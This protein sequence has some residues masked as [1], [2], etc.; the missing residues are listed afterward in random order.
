MKRIRHTLELAGVYL[1]LGISRIVPLRIAVKG[2]FLLGILAFD[3]FRIRRKVTL[4]NLGRALGGEM[5]PEE[6][7]EV[8]R[9]S[10]I[11][12][13]KSVI[14]FAAMGHLKEKD[15]RKLVTFRG[16]ENIETHLSG[17]DGIM[18]VAGH[19]GSW[20]LMGAASAA[21]GYPVDFLVGEQSN[22]MVNNLMNRLRSSA[23]I[24]IIEMGA[25]ARGIFKSLKKGRMVALLGDQDAR[26]MGIFVDFFGV[27]ASTYQG[28]AQFAYRTGSPVVV[29]S[30]IRDE[31]DRHEVV[32]DP[33]L[34]VHPELEEKE[35]IRRL[36]ALHTHQLE[37]RIREHPDHYFWAHRR[38]KT[39]PESMN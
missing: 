33:P 20:E 14:E 37:Q 8:A 11:N 39:R 36:T 23:G 17:G 26:R 32:F 29:A 35:E 12:F 28:A 5:G 19:F 13:A 15:Y 1:I 24:G 22:S 38:W 16:L 21:A 3:I 2:G 7:I 6:R 25:A 18:V 27:P 34:E 30:I 9:R 10:Y 4:E 31:K